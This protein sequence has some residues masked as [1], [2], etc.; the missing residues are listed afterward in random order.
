MQVSG[1]LGLSPQA[2]ETTRV[3]PG[4]KERSWPKHD[5]TEGMM[6]LADDNRPEA[7]LLIDLS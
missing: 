1:T 7:T 5:V 2:I 6:M 4:Q 3:L